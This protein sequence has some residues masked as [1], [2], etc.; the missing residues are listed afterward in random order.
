[1]R[2]TGGPII[3]LPQEKRMLSRREWLGL[4]LGTGAALALDTRMLSALRR[5]TPAHQL[6]T[7]AIPSTGERVPLVGSAAR[8]PSR[9]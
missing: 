3:N 6:I 2:S 5:L 8:P 4:T 1:M 7:R 9:R